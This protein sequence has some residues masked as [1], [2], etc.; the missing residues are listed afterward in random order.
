MNTP[1]NA[2]STASKGWKAEK[3]LNK[4][5]ATPTMLGKDGY[6][7][8]EYGLPFSRTDVSAFAVKM[9]KAETGCGGSGWVTIDAM[10]K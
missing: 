9:K 1:S 4:D 8:I 5:L 2:A 10:R 3:N 6:E 7:R